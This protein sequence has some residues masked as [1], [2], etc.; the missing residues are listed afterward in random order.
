MFKNFYLLYKTSNEVF[1]P[2]FKFNNDSST[3]SNN[4]CL[5]IEYTNIR[6]IL[7]KTEFVEIYVYMKNVDLL[8][9]T[10]TWLTPKFSDATIVLLIII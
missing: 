3:F 9:L 5:K 4:S 1:N 6:S 7:N 8:F 2:S 10:E